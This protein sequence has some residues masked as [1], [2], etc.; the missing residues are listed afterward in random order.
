[1]FVQSHVKIILNCIYWNLSLTN[2]SSVKLS[3]VS[4]VGVIVLK[5]VKLHPSTEYWI[6]ID[7]P[8]LRAEYHIQASI[9][10][11]TSLSEL[12]KYPLVTKYHEV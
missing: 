3:I 8:V 10:S 9:H 6:S 1:V 5:L 12:A 4:V 2:I 11:F 7:C